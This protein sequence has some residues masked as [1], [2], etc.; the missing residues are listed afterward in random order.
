MFKTRLL[1]GILLVLVALL[2]IIGGGSVL[3]VTLMCVSAIGMQE[4]YKVMQVRKE[5]FGAL[6][7]AGYLGM[8]LYYAGIF[9]DF[10]RYGMMAISGRSGNGC[11]FW[12]CLCWCNAFIY[13][14][15]KKSSGR[16]IPCLADFPLLVGM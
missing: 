16:K 1:S 14:S 4:L 9:L 15:Y 12:I 7:I 2:T 8:I 5:G 11:I 13:L 6:E 10:E 3:F